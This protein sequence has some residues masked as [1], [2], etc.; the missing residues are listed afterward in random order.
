LTG[1][2]SAHKIGRVKIEHTAYQ[3]E[4]PVALAR[5]Y[6]TNLGLSIKRSQSEAPFGYFL[7]DDGDTVMLEFYRQSLPVPDYRSLD[8]LLLHLAFLADDVAA[9]RTRLIAA[10]ATPEGEAFRNAA[11]DEVAMLRDPWGLAIQLI[12]RADPMIAPLG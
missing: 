12:K 9:T 8:P 6:V 2:S 10:G 5:W 1:S 7:A 4:D 3:V 11:G